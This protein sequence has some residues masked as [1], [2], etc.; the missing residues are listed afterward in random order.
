ME[1]LPVVAPAH[2]DARRIPVWNLDDPANKLGI[3]P[4]LERR[5]VPELRELKNLRLK[6]WQEEELNEHFSAQRKYSDTRSSSYNQSTYWVKTMRNV[7]Q[8]LDRVG[9]FVPYISRDSQ[10]EFLD[11]GCAPGGFSTYVL[12]KNVR[13]AGIGISLPVNAHGHLLAI[14]AKLRERY[15]YIEQ[16]VLGYDLSPDSAE[17]T[18]DGLN[19]LGKP[20]PEEYRCRFPL[21]MLDGHALRTYPS[22]AVTPEEIKLA[23]ANYRDALLI[24]QLIIAFMSTRA[25]KNDT[26]VVKL[27]HAECFPTAH[28]IYLLDTASSSLLLHKPRWTHS[29]RGTF[30]A[31]AKGVGGGTRRATMERYLEGLQALWHDLRFGGAEKQ[32]KYLVTTDLDFIVTADTILDEYL[33]RL[34]ELSL[35]VWST[36]ADGLRHFFQ[37]KGIQ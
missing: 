37:R 36:Q 16:D 17:R 14:D 12:S 21:V 13:S 5:D 22:N 24:G 28:L 25:G 34:I 15:Q 3:D 10:F 23:H 9:R 2:Q 4:I 33:D 7:L 6:G 30:Y 35:S 1:D 31:I 18:P 32:G 19:S 26:I 8:E 29:N 11:V 27:S 20:F